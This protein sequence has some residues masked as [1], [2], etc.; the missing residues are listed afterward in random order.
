MNEELEKQAEELYDF[1]CANRG[2]NLDKKG[3]P[4]DPRKIGCPYK[5]LFEET[6]TFYRNI[7]RWHL[8]K[9]NNS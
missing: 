3:N 8:N 1:L 9:K 4:G 7:V 6:K 5:D 2:D